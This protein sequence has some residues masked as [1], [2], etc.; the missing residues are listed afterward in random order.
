MENLFV[1]GTLREAHIQER[2]IG[3]II[4]NPSSDELQGYR[5]NWTLVAP[6]PVAMPSEADE[7]ISGLVLQVSEDELAAMDT[8]E[9][10]AY[11][12]VRLILMSGTEAWVYIGNPA[13]FRR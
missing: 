3:R 4:E 5:R 11:V 13:M 10:D 7:H 9:G 12:R 6:Y 8:Y 1:Y 2:L